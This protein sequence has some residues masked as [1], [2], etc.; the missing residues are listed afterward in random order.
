MEL[1]PIKTFQVSG[2]QI[3]SEHSSDKGRKES[4]AK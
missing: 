3:V 1:P 2:Y 4:M